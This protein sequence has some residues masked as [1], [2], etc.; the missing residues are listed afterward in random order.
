MEGVSAPITKYG[1]EWIVHSAPYFCH[2]QN[3]QYFYISH[4]HIT[5]LGKVFFNLLAKRNNV[6]RSC[7]PYFI[8]ARLIISV[9]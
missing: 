3:L 5:K 7:L 1:A 6:N 9:N 4:L 8:K 2:I